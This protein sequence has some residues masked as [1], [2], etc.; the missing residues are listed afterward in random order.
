MASGKP[1]PVHF[2]SQIRRS[3]MAVLCISVLLL[4]AGCS[5][6]KAP[7]GAAS[8]SSPSSPSSTSSA[9]AN[10][11]A[12]MFLDNRQSLREPSE[13]LKSAVGAGLAGFTTP[14]SGASPIVSLDLTISNLSPDRDLA[15]LAVIPYQVGNVE[16][17]PGARFMPVSGK[18]FLLKAGEVST[19]TVDAQRERIAGGVQAP[20]VQAP[21]PPVPPAKVQSVA[22]IDLQRAQAGDVSPF[23]PGQGLQVLLVCQFAN[24]VPAGSWE[25]VQSVPDGEFQQRYGDYAGYQFSIGVPVERLA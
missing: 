13:A 21:A 17:G 19:V 9:A 12:K 24:E 22:A 11:V 6:S 1:R 23:D 25:I 3:T 15:F 16:T 2:D 5:D 10:P 4:V 18:S 7:S 14:M 20:G 8:P